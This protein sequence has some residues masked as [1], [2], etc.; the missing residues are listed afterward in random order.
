MGLE[1]VNLIDDAQLAALLKKKERAIEQAFKK[2]GKGEGGG[3]P[4]FTMGGWEFPNQT[5]I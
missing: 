4:K 3:E 1:M 5:E 2:E